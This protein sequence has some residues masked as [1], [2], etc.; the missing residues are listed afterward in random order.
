[1]FFMQYNVK[2][3]PFNKS[4]TTV[5]NY[6][7]TIASAEEAVMEIADTCWHRKSCCGAYSPL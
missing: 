7:E 2:Y 3:V 1:M 5:F 4:Y 6:L